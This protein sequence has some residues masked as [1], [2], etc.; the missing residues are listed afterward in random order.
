MRT[1]IATLGVLSVA[2]LALAQ[3]DRGTITGTISDPAGA[4]VANAPIQARNVETGGAYEG[5]TSTTGNYTL[6]QL[7]AG[8]YEVSIAVP[9]FK[10]FTRAGL[11][12]QVAVTLRID[13]TLEVGATSESVTVTEAAPLL[14]TESGELSHNV[15]SKTL[16]DLPLAGVGAQQAGSGG[17]RNPNAMVVLIPGTVW[18]AN[19]QLKINGAPSNTQSFRI[20][21]QD[22]SNTG[23]PG[24]AAQTQPSIDAIQEVAIQTSNYAAEFG[25]VGGG[26]FNITMRSGTNQF[27]GAAYDYF[28]NEIFN[29]GHPFFTGDPRG[30]PRDR[31]RRNDYGFSGGGP[32]WIPKVYNGHDK[33]FFFFNI[34]QYR[35]TLNVN[36]FQT[37]PT[38]A[39]RQ[40]NFATAITNKVIGTDPVTKTTMLEGMIYDPSTTRTINNQVVRDQFPNNKIDPKFF[41]PVAAKIQTLFPATNGP[42]PN[43]LISN[44]INPF[45]STRVVTIPS[46]KVDQSIGSKGKLAFYFQKTN[47]SSPVAPALGQAD[48]LPDP[49]TQAIGSFTTAF[50]YRLNYDYTLTPTMLLHL[51]GGYRLNLFPVPS[52]TTKG[53][54]TNYDA[55]KELGLKG[56][57]THRFFPIMTGMLAGNGTGGMK[58]I[59]SGSGGHSYAENPTFN[60]SLNWVRSNHTYKFGSEGRTEG[61]IPQGI[62]NDGTYAFSQAQTGQPFQQTAVG[63]A[64]TGFGYASFILGQVNSVTIGGPTNPRGGKKQIGFFAQ[65]SWKVTRRLTFDY[66]VRYDYSTYLRDGYGRLPDFSA[67]AIHPKLGIPGASVYDGNGPGRCNCDIAHNYPYAAAPRLGAAYQINPK[68]VFRAG[69]GIVYSGTEHNNN[70]I[71]GLAG[72]SATT[73]S[74]NFGLP[75]TTL[76]QG[77]PLSFRPP[78]WP[79]YDPAQFP[80]GLPTPGPG[81]VLMDPGAG[82]PGRQ[83]QFSVRLQREITKDL[84]V[85]AS[86]VGQR[87]VWWQ[88]PGLLNINAIS[89][90][91]LKVFGLDLNN[92]ADRTLLTSQ[93]G[94]AA[95]AARGF[96][97]LPYAGFPS[98]QLVAQALRPFPQ[99]TTLNVYWDPLG[100]SWYDGLQAK[101]TKRFSHGLSFLSTFAWQKTMTLASEVGAPNP[102]TSGNAFLGDVFNR[103]TNK[104][105]SSSDQPSVFNLYM[106][107]KSPTL[108]G[109]KWVSWA[110]RDWTYGAFL[111]YVSG[112][113]M[114]VPTAQSTPSMTS[115]TFQSTYANRVA[116]QPL[117]TV[118]L[119][120][121]CYDPNKTFVLNKNAWVDPLPGQYGASA[122]LYS[123]YRTQRHPV[124]NMN[125]GRTF[126][127]K[128]RASFNLRIEFSNIFNRSQWNDPSGTALTTA[129]GSG[130]AQTFK[131]NGNTASGFGYVDTTTQGGNGTVNIQPRTGVLVGRFT[132]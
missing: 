4:V 109:N 82:R 126:R 88:A 115:L 63:G 58:V 118:D 76:A 97:R 36:L 114:V 32:V 101:V 99:F 94:S 54:L 112:V 65:D 104:Y 129:T 84:A 11:Q 107:Y 18:L 91:R 92:A 111:Q 70:A 125:L 81:P 21:G 64:N 85:E 53:D 46:I 17:I 31:Q 72:S 89:V 7:P 42:N 33:T 68:T 55:E 69:F 67:T 77:I 102:G 20:E 106:N 95:A 98:T 25:Q 86:Y 2:S 22:A 73:S 34:E 60:A 51:G 10:K 57:I 23:T 87:G 39:Y 93:V 90:D 45:L 113:P 78:A 79:T 120:C 130:A 26:V 74:A 103:N 44:Y 5:A 27:H 100:K 50:I 59:G 56:G 49:I 43:D 122:A 128:E 71:G 47:S 13:I 15:T 29:G 48:G 108:H 28:V 37:I 96:N 127:F 40:G 30:N 62:G 14:N 16:D 75:V 12:V 105:I 80:T 124:E 6:T 121:H 117:Y 132:F 131:A 61:Y 110:A 41:D 116:G 52:V 119:N 38:T 123:D 9:G 24:T 83:Y 3:S 35:E 66:G 1:L 19:S 8:T